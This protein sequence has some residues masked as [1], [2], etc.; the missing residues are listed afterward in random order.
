MNARIE[1]VSAEPNARSPRRAATKGLARLFTY[2][3]G[4]EIL[5]LGPSGA[6]K[7]KFTEYLRLGALDPASKREMT[8]HIRKSP[9]FVVGFGSNR[10]VTLK[11]RRA[12]DTPG[13]VGPWQ[14]GTLVGRR[15]PHAIIVVLDSTT[16]LSTTVAWLRLFCSRL[17][18]VLRDRSYVK[19]KLSEILILLN[20]RDRIDDHQFQQLQ[21]GVREVL[22]QHLTIVLGADRARAI[23]VVE[24]ISVQ[25]DHGTELID[26]VIGYLSER[27]QEG[28]K[29][30]TRI[31][32]TST[33][34]H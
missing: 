34:Y 11:V 22:E 23:P 9:S 5:V 30:G 27:L 25:T 16:A 1:T 3:V 6:G 10:Q 28:R 26:F 8:Y 4:K 2:A 17:D 18:T 13:Q 31:P 21:A 33:E 32:P 12:V 29:L 24:C 20:K 15:K 14:H 7:T 19:R